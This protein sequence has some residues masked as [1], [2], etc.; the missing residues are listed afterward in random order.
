MSQSRL[1]SSSPLISV[2]CPN[3]WP[4]FRYA[5]L[6]ACLQIEWFVGIDAVQ[7][8]T[9]PSANDLDGDESVDVQPTG[10]PVS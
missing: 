6:W 8:A 10:V 2:V 9:A 5:R 1:V 7:Y 3:T 4:S